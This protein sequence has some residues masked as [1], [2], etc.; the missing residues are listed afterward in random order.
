MTK[1]LTATIC[2]W[3]SKDELRVML[4]SLKAYDVLLND[5]NINHSFKLG[6]S[7]QY[8]PEEVWD[9]LNDRLHKEMKEIEEHI[10]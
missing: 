8:I 4:D 10:G 6:W 7:P 1:D 3:L 2:V 5:L 9:E